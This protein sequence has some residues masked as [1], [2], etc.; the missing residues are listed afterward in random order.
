MAAY[1]YTLSAPP[2]P[3]NGMY[4]NVPGKG[5]RKT[6]AY[7]RWRQAAAWELAAQRLGHGVGTIAVP[8]AV[9]ICLPRKTRGDA[10][11]RI[12]GALD[13][14]K[15]GGVVVDDALC[16]PVTIGRSDVALTTITITPRAAE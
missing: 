12:K 2:T 16:D 9:S 14:L 6:P 1:T 4:L 8:M 11:G 7:R 10:D 3:V 15:D 5:R 13:A